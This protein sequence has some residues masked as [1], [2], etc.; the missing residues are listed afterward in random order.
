MSDLSIFFGKVVVVLVILH[1][2]NRFFNVVHGK[3]TYTFVLH[4]Q[5]H[6]HG[7]RRRV[8]RNIEMRKQ[9]FELN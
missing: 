2:I 4:E 7:F 6:F 3:R 1:V 5:K 8:S 9:R